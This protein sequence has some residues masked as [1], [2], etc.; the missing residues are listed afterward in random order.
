MGCLWERIVA[1]SLDFTRSRFPASL[2]L[3]LSLTQMVCFRHKTETNWQ[4]VKLVT[5]SCGRL[6]AYFG[7]SFK[8]IDGHDILHS[9]FDL[10]L[11]VV[12]MNATFGRV[13]F[14]FKLRSRQ[15]RLLRSRELCQSPLGGIFFTLRFSLV[16]NQ[17]W[18]RSRDRNY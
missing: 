10:L 11:Y 12:S 15:C 13:F 16:P 17:I 3:K 7:A 4:K 6:V 2:L 9:N 8:G 1:K 14:F 18:F 5:N